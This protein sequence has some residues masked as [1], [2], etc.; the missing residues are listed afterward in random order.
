MHDYHLPN[1]NLRHLFF[2]LRYTSL[3]A[4]KPRIP[5]FSTTESNLPFSSQEKN[6]SRFTDG[7]TSQA[8]RLRIIRNRTTQRDYQPVSWLS[9]HEFY[10][11][12]LHVRITSSID[13]PTIITIW[14]FRNTRSRRPV[15][16]RWWVR[17][18]PPINREQ[19][20]T[21]FPLS[22]RKIGRTV[23]QVGANSKSC[24]A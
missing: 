5:I 15:G 1:L 6:E 7:A 18:V 13:P 16:K 8:K 3:S 17:R 14:R 9:R 2:P 10:V 23:G 11:S 24:P 22:C 20:R 4:Q 19:A 21:S 12:S